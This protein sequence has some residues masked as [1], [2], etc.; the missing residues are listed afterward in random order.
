MLNN[1]DKPLRISD[2]SSKAGLSESRFFGLFRADTGFS[3]IGF[4]IRLRLL[5]ACE[6]LMNESLSIKQ[7]AALSG[8]KDSFYFSRQFKSIN[9]ASPSRY[10]RFKARR[11]YAAP[12][13]KLER[14]D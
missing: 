8:Y 2:L 3:P 4:F 9:G 6:L 11:R 13:K 5:R 1:Q 10:R 12:I 14:G 7:V